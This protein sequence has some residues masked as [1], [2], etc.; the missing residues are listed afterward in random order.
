MEAKTVPHEVIPC[1]QLPA[2][3]YR[4]LPEPPKWRKMIG[5]SILLLGLSLGSGEFVLWPYISDMS[6]TDRCETHAQVANPK[7]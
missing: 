5:P 3:Q 1:D 2:G 7:W 4:D 6:Q